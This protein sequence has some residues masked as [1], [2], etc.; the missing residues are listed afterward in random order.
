MGILFLLLSSVC[1]AIKLISVKKCGAS[2]E[3]W[4]NSVK[5]NFFRAAGCLAVSGAVFAFTGGFTDGTGLVV[6]LLSGVATALNMIVYLLASERT[7]LCAV[8]IFCMIGAVIVPML[9]AP[10]LYEGEKIGA[11]QWCGA[12]LL[13]AAALL[14]A[15][16]AGAR[17][18]SF[19]A[20]ILLSLCT[21]A[22]AGIFVTQKLF[23]TYASGSVACFNLLNF[24]VVFLL[25]GAAFGAVAGKKRLPS[26][27]SE[28]ENP[29]NGGNIC[30]F[31]RRIWLLIAVSTVMQYC[32]QYFSA[33]ASGYFSSAVFYPL[34]YAIAIPLTFI[35]DLF[36]FKE[37]FSVR[38]LS[39]VMC[40][41]AAMVFVNL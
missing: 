11:L 22:N 19:R 3:G 31:S 2:A 10:V 5:I 24:A 20:A 41:V 35:V 32:N 34:T 14:L 23:V 30:G 9:L 36:V 16:G 12:G 27:G 26:A 8:E 18:F 21:V 6:S 40:A 7:S 28:G 38:K 29:E 39:G 37:K 17:R 25:L 13:F 1:A 33:S 4:F 15:G